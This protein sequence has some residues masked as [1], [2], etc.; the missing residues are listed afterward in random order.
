MALFIVINIKYITARADAIQ[1]AGHLTLCAL[2]HS[3]AIVNALQVIN[4]LTRIH[5]NKRHS[6]A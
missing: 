3:M 5:L 4:Q 6:H 2:A 1:P